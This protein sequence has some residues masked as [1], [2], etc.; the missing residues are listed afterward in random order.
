[1]LLG[2]E[3]ACA[4]VTLLWLL[5]L[6]LFA[7]SRVDCA[8]LRTEL[9]K[10]DGI[11]DLE[12]RADEL[13]S[14]AEAAQAETARS[15]AF[16]EQLAGR[17]NAQNSTIAS[18]DAHIAEQQRQM[19]SL[20]TRL[21]AYHELDGIR[22]QIEKQKQ[23]V[24]QYNQVL[25]NFRSADQLKTHIAQQTNRVQQ[26]SQTIGKFETVAQL[27]AH[28]SAQRAQI[29]ELETRVKD[30]GDVLGGAGTAIELQNQIKYQENVLAEL[31]SQVHQVEETLAMQEFGFYRPRYDFE[32]SS[33]YQKMLDR[34]R[35]RQ[36]QMIKEDVAVAW[37]KQWVVEGS[38][39]KGR[40]MMKEQT[41]LMLRA[42][43]GECDASVAKVRFDNATNMETRI[44]RSCE[45]INKLGKTNAA[46]ITS[47]FLELKLQ[48]LYL[49]HE[50]RVKKQE[51]K[52]E[53]QRIKALMRE[54]EKVQRELEKA[55]QEADKEEVVAERA[56]EKARLEFERATKNQKEATEKTK[57]HNAA[58]AAQI[59]KLEN[60]LSEAIDR[61]AKAIARAQ[62]TKSGHIYVLSNIGSFGENVYK[63]GM[64]RRLEPLERVKELGDASV[65]FRFD[66]H[67]MV[68]SENAPDLE[69]KL[70]HHFAHRRVNLINLRR[71]YFHATLEEIMDA[72]TDHFGDVTFVKTPEAAEYRETIAQRKEQP[73]F[74]NLPK[75]PVLHQPAT[76]KAS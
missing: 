2:F 7:K 40:K 9:Q 16:L 32:S 29:A 26:L 45:Q 1:M 14:Q 13:G 60:E 44:S 62:L 34:T 36:K 25:G 53:Q 76:V 39:A 27:D 22:R 20:A 4:V 15:Q 28:I 19:T 31:Q 52:E 57:V 38:E 48:E 56:L 74:Q 42:F 23:Q 30:L 43:N 46:N 68:Y 3:I 61:K 5:F 18:Q 70:H 8:T 10:F 37:D 17:I 67:A 47:G 65:P 58:L 50:H 64:T 11:V 41:K 66:V 51:E 71:E 73:F 21:G 35:E 69:N 6:V 75:R 72:V 59:A 33:E 12:G 55:K 49:V 54:E 63:I 24:S